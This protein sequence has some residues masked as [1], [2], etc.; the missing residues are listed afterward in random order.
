MFFETQ[1]ILPKQVHGRQDETFICYKSKKTAV[2]EK[3][4]V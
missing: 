2:I 3:S 1:C 4:G